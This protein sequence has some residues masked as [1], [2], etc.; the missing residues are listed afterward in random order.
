MAGAL[1]PLAG[2]SPPADGVGRD[3]CNVCVRELGPLGRL[4]V[5]SDGAHHPVGGPDLDGDGDVSVV[6]RLRFWSRLWAVTPRSVRRLVVVLV[7]STLIVTGAVLVVVPGP[8]TLPL[9]LAGLAVLA[10]E[11]MWG[12]RLLRYGRKR[13]SE[14]TESLKRVDIG[15]FKRVFRRGN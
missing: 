6:E 7:G 1:R 9:V 8:F 13:V 11:F 3:E 15:A 14:T 5:T 10:T 4:A 2:V 12:G